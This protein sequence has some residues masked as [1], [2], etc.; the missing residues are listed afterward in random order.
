MRFAGRTALVTGSSSGNGR[1]IALRLAAEGASVMCCDIR[2]DGRP[3][4][5]DE[6]PDV[7]THTLINERGG[8]AA[9]RH[10]DA[11]IED[12]VEQ[13]FADTRDQIGDLDIAVLNAGI[14]HRDASLLDET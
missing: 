7:P 8:K 11:T 12:S 4:G 3:G 1:A 2:P 5:F 6:A 9:Y 13:A 14:F 10:C